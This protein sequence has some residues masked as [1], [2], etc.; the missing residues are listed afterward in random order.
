MRS[1][2]AC[3]AVLALV[4]GCAGSAPSPSPSPS[5]SP[6]A[7]T[8][9]PVTPIPA[10]TP[11][12]TPMPSASSTPTSPPTLAA[13]PFAV[14]TPVANQTPGA[15]AGWIQL[16]GYSAT[17]APGGAHFL[18][19]GDGGGV[20][21]DAT[22]GYGPH[23]SLTWASWLDDSHLIGVAEVNGWRQAEVVDIQTGDITVV[24]PPHPLD[25]TMANGR[26]VAALTWTRDNDWPD[27]HFSY[28][29]WHDGAFGEVEDGYPQQWSADG[30][31]LALLHQFGRNRSPGGWLSVVAS[32][33]QSV[34]FE[35][36]PPFAT[37]DD[38]AFDPSSRYVA[39]LTESGRDPHDPQWQLLLRVVDLETTEFVDLPLDEY[40][41]FFWNPDSTITTVEHGSLAQRTYAATGELIEET[42]AA[43]SGGIRSDDGSTVVFSDWEDTTDV[44]TVVRDG[45]ESTIRAPGPVGGAILS[46]DGSRLI[47]EVGYDTYLRAL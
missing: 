20:V 43:H 42:Q 27:A 41:Y 12:S 46:P 30:K 1:V 24:Q 11:S 39:Y 29:L 26:G 31:E 7:T 10:S 25:E 18:S 34:L 13:T 44:L 23:V 3:A 22:G 2:V 37:G 17:W 32:P 33:D 47:V 8:A 19:V 16:S 15:D 45:R 40:G 5:P 6:M 28:V 21:Y 36:A 4:V 38:V 9:V 14:A 35:D